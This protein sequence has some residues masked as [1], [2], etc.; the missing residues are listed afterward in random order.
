MKFSGDAHPHLISLLATYEQFKRFY[1]IFPWAQGD[2]VDYW[3]KKNKYPSVDYENILW[4]AAQISGIT[5]GL[6]KIHRY[7]STDSKYHHSKRHDAQ[8]DP[9]SAVMSFAIPASKHRPKQ[10][11]GRHGDIKPQNIL[12]F[13]DPDDENDKGILKITDFGLTEFS[14]NHSKSYKPNN[15]IAA[16]PSY[17]PP[18]FDLQDGLIG[19]SYD[20]W[21]L[22]CLYLELITWFLGGWDFAEKFRVERT[23]FDPMW[24]DYHTDT[25]FEIVR[26][27]VTNNTLGAMVKPKVTRVTIQN[28]LN[29]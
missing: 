7:E 23:A 5:D 9:R 10:L 28:H 19:R 15:N 14:A 17:R 21:T 22:G 6:S 1:L 29:E 8:L 4:V 2:L 18:E 27:K 20:I 16:S 26:C 12:W 24:F 13:Q 3:S 25:F 11:F